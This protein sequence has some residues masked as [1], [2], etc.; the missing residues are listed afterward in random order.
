MMLGITTNLD[1]HCQV[2]E[3]QRVLEYITGNFLM[4]FMDQDHKIIKAQVVQF[5]SVLEYKIKMHVPR[6]CMICLCAQSEMDMALISYVARVSFLGWGC[7]LSISTTLVTS[8]IEYQATY[9]SSF[10]IGGVV[11]SS[12]DLRSTQIL[13]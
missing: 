4:E 11:G 13:L 2:L 12:K 10:S 5:L 7:C 3:Q 1:Q 9:Y 6:H 8:A